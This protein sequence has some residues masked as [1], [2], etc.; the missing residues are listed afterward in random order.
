VSPLILEDIGW[1]PDDV[2]KLHELVDADIDYLS[3]NGTD[4]SAG[5]FADRVAGRRVDLL[6]RIRD[7]LPPIEYVP[8]SSDRYVTGRRHH[9]PAPKKT[10]K[11]LLAALDAVDIP[12]AGG[13]VVILDRE[14]GA[15]LYASRLEAIIAARQLDDTEQ[16]KIA[17]GLSYFEFPRLNRTDETAFVELCTGADLAVFDSQRT[18][19]S[20]LGLDENDSD[21]YARFMAALID[22]LFRAGIATLILDN[23]GHGD[24]KRGRGSSS[25]GDLNEILFTIDAVEPFDADTTGRLRLDI[26]DSRLGTNGRWELDIGGGVFGHWRSVDHL[27]DATGF[28]PTGLMERAS[29]FVENCAEPP[30]RTMAAKATG[31]K[32]LY[33]RIAIDRLVREGYMRGPKRGGLEVIRPYREATDPLLA[34]A[35]DDGE[36]DDIPW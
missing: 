13:H 24:P 30:A 9:L 16:D 23:A 29:I 32:A 2:A 31:G 34:A 22:P 1:D 11:S 15:N 8:G 4:P 28:R 26:A 5:S 19:L 33:A 17:A 21:D 3:R 27:D 25:K 18:F 35:E 12:L 10:G 36:E 6:A 20:D 7:G 14:N